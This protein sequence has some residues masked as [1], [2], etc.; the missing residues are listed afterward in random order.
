MDGNPNRYGKGVNG[1]LKWKF[2]QTQ[3]LVDHFIDLIWHCIQQWGCFGMEKRWV[4]SSLCKVFIRV[5]WFSLLFVP[6]KV[7]L[8]SFLINLVV[9]HD[10]WKP[11][12]LSH[13]GPRPS[14]FMIVDDLILF[15]EDSLEQVELIGN[16]LK[17]FCA[18]SGQRVNRNKTHIFLK[19]WEFAFPR[20]IKLMNSLVSP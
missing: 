6:L 13:E 7:I 17:L 19:K 4:L 16:C 1:R 12:Q 20:S 2:V 14:Y 15:V 3:I 5:T 10:F 9:D 8:H 18:S 11:I